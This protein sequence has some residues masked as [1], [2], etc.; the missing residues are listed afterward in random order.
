MYFLTYSIQQKV[1]FPDALKIAKIT[2]IFKTGGETLL[3]NYRPISVLSAYSKI[4]ERTMYLKVR[5]FRGNLISRFYV[6]SIISWCS[7]LFLAYI[8][9]QNSG[10]REIFF[11]RKFLTLRYNKIYKYITENKLLYNKQFGFQSNKS[12]EQ[13]SLN[14]VDD[15]KNAFDRGEFTLGIFIDLAKAFDTVDHHILLQKLK[16][17]RI[18]SHKDQY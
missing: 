11:P 18:R 15:I 8:I 9:V 6:S 12:T 7:S 3:T 10:I 13:C 2:P 14:L 16:S 5:N 4:I 1:F 17:Y